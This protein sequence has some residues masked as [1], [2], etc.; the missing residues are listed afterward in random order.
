MFLRSVR[1]RTARWRRAEQ[2]DVH[3]AGDHWIVVGRVEAR[4]A[5]GADEPLI[6]FGLAFGGLA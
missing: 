6:L 1:T 3:P 5:S 4:R 2:V